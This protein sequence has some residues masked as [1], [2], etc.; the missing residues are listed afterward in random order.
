MANQ[1]YTAV[2]EADII[3]LYNGFNCIFSPVVNLIGINPFNWLRLVFSDDILR[4]I[5]KT[6]LGCQ[7]VTLNTPVLL[8]LILSVTMTTLVKRGF[9]QTIRQNY[10]NISV[11]RYC[12]VNDK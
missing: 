8:M 4:L 6:I 11:V 1:L 9:T 12:V 10:E 2:G 3:N 7:F 5:A